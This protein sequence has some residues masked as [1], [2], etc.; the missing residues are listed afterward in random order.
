MILDISNLDIVYPDKTKA[1]DK[2]N[3]Q[4]KSGESLALAGANGAGKT[5]LLLAIAGIVPVSKGCIQVDGIT[6]TKKTLND[7]RA[8]VGLIF[9]NPDDQLFMTRVFD[10]VAFGPRNYGVSEDEVKQRVEQALSELGITRLSKR[11]VL[12]LSAGEK[13]LA[14]IATVLSMRPAILLFDEPTAFLDL[15]ARRNMIRLLNNM[16]YAKLIVSH[17]LHF[18][19]ETCERAVLM[20]DGSVFAEGITKDIFRNETLM[21]DCGLEGIT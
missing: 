16:P 19:E 15:K 17:D 9:Q 7:I 11:S 10:D 2:F 18:L 3:L 20:K 12:K 14:A 21:E 5:T 6:L 13:R 1:V 4:I 8:R